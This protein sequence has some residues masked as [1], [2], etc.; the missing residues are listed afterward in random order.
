VDEVFETTA[1]DDWALKDICILIIRSGC[2]GAVGIERL[3][4]ALQPVFCKH[5]SLVEKIQLFPELEGGYFNEGRP[6]S[7][8]R[9]SEEGVDGA[10]SESIHSFG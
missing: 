8:E 9:E 7:L 4:D 3:L 2:F 5:S 1:P 6:Y 10:Q